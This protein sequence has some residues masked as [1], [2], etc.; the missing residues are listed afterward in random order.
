MTD[1]RPRVLSLL[2]T[3]GEATTGFQVLEPGFSYA[4]EDEGCVAYVDTGGAWVVAGTPIAPPRTRATLAARF[5][6]RAHAAG[7]RVCFFSVDAA[8]AAEAGLDA[9]PIGEEPE[10]DPRAWPTLL[11][12]ARRLREQL[13]RARAKGVT[14]RLVA[15]REVAEGTALR[16]GFLVDL[17]PFEFPGEHVY[18]VAER[19]GEIVGFAAAVPI[20]ARDG[21]LLED[22]LRTDEAPNGTSELLV[23]AVFRAI[24][25]RG[26]RHVTLGLAPLSG[27]VPPVLATIARLGRS[28][29]DFQGVR[30][31]KARLRPHAW[32]RVFLAYPEGQGALAAVHDTLRAFA[33]GGFVR[34][35]LASLRRRPQWIVWAAVAV[36]LPIALLILHHGWAALVSVGLSLGGPLLTDRRRGATTPP[37]R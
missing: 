2:R 37:C 21:Y 35:G 22:L 4:F 26:A 8:F 15:A 28:L 25:E 3:H 9:L 11:R 33:T 13:R 19:H 24:A 27:E 14:V 5:V 34:F 6:Q 7:R 31:F 29:Y 32:S 23:D 17:H 12:S 30:A 36:L 1:Q 20:H 16:V 18:A 10:W